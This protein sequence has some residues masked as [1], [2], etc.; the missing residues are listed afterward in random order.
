MNVDCLVFYEN[1]F[2]VWVLSYEIVFI[3]KWN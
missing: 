2:V 1:I 3:S